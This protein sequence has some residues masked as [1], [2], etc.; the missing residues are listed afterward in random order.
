MCVSC[1]PPVLLVYLRKK[2][3]QIRAGLETCLMICL[4]VLRGETGR[5]LGVGGWGGGVG[6][7]V[8]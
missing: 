1:G 3:L 4:G 6:F 8:R 5:R 2:P 7:G